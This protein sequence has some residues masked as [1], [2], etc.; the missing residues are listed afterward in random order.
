MINSIGLYNFNNSNNVSFSAKAV[1][2]SV[3][4]FATSPLNWALS[5]SSLNKTNSPSLAK[6]NTKLTS[7]DD[8]KMYNE[9]LS[10]FATSETEKVSP[11]DN[12]LRQTKLNALLKNGTLLN[13]NSNDRTS[14]LE[15]IYKAAVTER[16]AGMDGLKI[17]GQI[18]DTVYNPAIITQK[19]GDI[20][21]EAQVFILNKDKNLLN[22]SSINVEGSG[23]CVAASVEFH[24]A[25]KHPAEFS[26][27]AESLTSPKVEVE[28]NINLSALSKNTMDALWL[29]KEF[30]VKPDNFNF[31]RPK[32]RIKPDENAIVRAQIQD[33]FWDK[34]ERSV[35]DVLFQSTLM[36]LGSQ[37]SYDSLTDT[38]GGK[39][40]SNPQ[41]L[42][43]FEKTFIESI[44]ENS[45]RTSVVYQNVDNNQNLLG[46]NCDMADIQ[47]HITEA[48]DSGE[49]V[50]IGYVLTAEECNEPADNPKKIVNG[51]EITIVDYKKDPFGNMTFICNDTDD[52]KPQ[53]VEYSANYLLPKIHHASYPVQIVEQE[54]G[55]KTA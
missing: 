17:A 41:G 22:S 7:A 19:F 48:I 50:I 36:Q 25:N 14:V 12:T 47:K 23:T 2:N 27:W 15:N 3:P 4:P 37:Q 9:I 55:L 6:V 20:P 24:M 42:I 13:R 33:N 34:G 32:L 31:Y 28:K 1:K 26:R 44:V 10:A 18:I 11:V 54:M 40:N 38:R 35:L 8:I 51:H 39:F 52:D 49:D 43:E 5:G 46:W 16:A 29:L 45:E 21:K 30:E 53:L